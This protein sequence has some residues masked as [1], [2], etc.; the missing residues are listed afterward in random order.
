[1]L[2]DMDDQDGDAPLQWIYR[3]LY[4]VGDV[5]V[6]LNMMILGA[7]LADGGSLT[8]LPLRVNVGIVLA[9]MVGLP[10]LMLCA[11]GTLRPLLMTNLSRQIRET[12]WLVALTCSCTPTANNINVLAQLGKQNTKSLAASIFLQYL[13]APVLL[14][15]SLS[16]FIGLIPSVDTDGRTTS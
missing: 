8:A 16:L 5:A 4:R 11:V 1:M 14:S 7:T 13:C 12:I 10:L 6:P 3:G 2:V 15:I 9:K